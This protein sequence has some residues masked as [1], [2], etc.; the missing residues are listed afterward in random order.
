MKVACLAQLV[1]VIAPI[2]T[3]DGGRMFEQTIYFPFAHVSNFGRGTVLNQ[4]IDCPKH[5]TK[6]FS[7][8]P[9][10]DSVSVLSEN[11]DSL[12]VFAVNRTEESV[13]FDVRMIEMGE[14]KPIEFIRMAGF[15]IKMS[16]GFD[17]SPVKPKNIDLPDMNGDT[18]SIPLAP[19]SWNVI[20]F[21]KQ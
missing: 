8:V 19:L 15:D 6:E 21:K 2:M 14:M 10:I 3:E 1:N 18:A 20:R 12:T 17:A 4:V 16:N 9:D 7:D 13:L 5:D 11:E